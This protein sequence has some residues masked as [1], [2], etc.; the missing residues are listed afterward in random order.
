MGRGIDGVAI[1][2]GGSGPSALQCVMATAKTIS[3]RFRRGKPIIGAMLPDGSGTIIQFSRD[4]L[5]WFSD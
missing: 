1:D 3:W 5:N 2:H 4:V